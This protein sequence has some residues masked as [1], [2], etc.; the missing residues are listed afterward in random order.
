[1]IILAGGG[2]IEGS[3][4]AKRFEFLRAR[5]AVLHPQDRSGVTRAGQILVTSAAVE[6]TI[7]DGASGTPQLVDN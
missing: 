4:R 5:G 2:R 6:E 3:G 1:L 7:P